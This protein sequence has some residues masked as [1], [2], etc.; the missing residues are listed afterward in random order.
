M[1]RHE[2][3][4]TKV[5]IAGILTIIL[6]LAVFATAVAP[7]NA[8]E[9]ITIVNHHGNVDSAGYYNVV[10]EVK[11]TGDTP[12]KNVYVKITFTS[13]EGP[14]EDETEIQLHTLLPGRKAPFGA[15]AGAAGSTVTSYT[16]ELMELTMATEDMPKVLSIQSSSS[17][18]QMMSMMV[19]GTVKNTGTETATYTRVYATFYD[20]PSGTGNVVGATG[21]TAQP[22]NLEA[23]QTGNFDIGFVT[24]PGK[25][26]ASYVVVAESDQYA[27]TT[28]YVATAGQTSSPAPSS[29]ANLNP[30]PSVP[31]FPTPIV[32]PV[33]IAAL[34][35]VAVALSK[36]R[37]K[38]TQPN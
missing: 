24:T 8:A 30:S 38:T 7:V 4:K 25:T 3:Q 11:N 20:G 9:Q 36:R 22:Y 29:S 26:Y 35:V 23:G 27:A 19:T 12:A 1:R 13:P 17:Q 32:A 15:T 16:I 18:V 2:M 6:T 14:D 28:E 21:G 31:E 33:L 5:T 37:H 34:L 10:G